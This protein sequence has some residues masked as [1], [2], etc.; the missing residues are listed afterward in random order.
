MVDQDSTH[1]MRSDRKKVRAVLPFRSGLLGQPKVCLVNQSS[2]L[3][4]VVATLGT[5]VAASKPTEFLINDREKLVGCVLVAFAPIP[6]QS[7]HTLV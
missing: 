4:C 1:H 2:R 5:H 3:K 7:G 6:Q